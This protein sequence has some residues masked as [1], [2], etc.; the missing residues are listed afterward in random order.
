MTHC[1]MIR[2]NNTLFEGVSYHLMVTDLFYLQTNIDVYAQI[3]RATFAAVSRQ[4]KVK[5]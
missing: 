4:T 1:D 5:S 3:V 2:T